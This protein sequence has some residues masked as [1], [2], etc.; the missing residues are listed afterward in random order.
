MYKLVRYY[1]GEYSRISLD[2]KEIL[3]KCFEEDKIMA[4]GA[5]IASIKENRASNLDVLVTKM[6]GG[7]RKFILNEKI[8]QKIEKLIEDNACITLK[9]IQQTVFKTVLEYYN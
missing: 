4:E 8:L 9:S 3:L 7:K 5:R 2:K 6:L 1:R